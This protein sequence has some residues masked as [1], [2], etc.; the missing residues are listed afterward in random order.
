M[1]TVRKWSGR[2]TRALREAKRMSVR[3]FA[4][5]L[6]VSDRAVSKWEAGGLIYIPD[7]TA[8]RSWTLPLID[9]LLK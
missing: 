1:T 7:R 3:E 4:A 6:G 5:H 9:H 8:R 2:E